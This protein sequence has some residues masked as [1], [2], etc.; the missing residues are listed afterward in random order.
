LL[1]ILD[2]AITFSPQDSVIEINT[3]VDNQTV[4]CEIKDSGPGF[5]AGAIDRV[6]DLFVTGDPYIDNSTGIGLPIASMIM[7]AHGGN[8]IIDNNPEGGASVK[9]LFHNRIVDYT[10]MDS[11]GKNTMII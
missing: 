8:I 1:L 3:Y 10:T 4:I 11:V 6:F 9:L 2:N 5:A 7:D